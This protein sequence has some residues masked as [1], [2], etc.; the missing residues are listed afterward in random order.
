MCTCDDV[1][2]IA[3]CLHVIQQIHPEKSR[4]QSSAGD[5]E[6]RDG[7]EQFESQNAIGLDV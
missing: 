6:S 5:D 1:E 3:V 2:Y 4:D 7:K